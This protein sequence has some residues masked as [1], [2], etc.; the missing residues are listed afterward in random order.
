M[1]WTQVVE[2]VDVDDKWNNFEACLQTL[3]LV[4]IPMQ[5]VY[6][7]DRDKQWITPLIKLLINQRWHAYRTKNWTLY[8][9]L[10]TK[11]RVEITKAKHSW[12]KKLQ[13][14]SYGIW[15]L[16]K[17]IT[18]KSRKSD[19]SS[20]ISKFGSTEA[21]VDALAEHFQKIASRQVK[22]EDVKSAHATLFP[23]APLL[24]AEGIRKRS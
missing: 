10:K 3:L 17:H 5:E 15:N 24:T 20:L 1:D 11:V 23:K 7:T 18:N 16:A 8:D 2:A 6:M 22:D 4:C 14:C 19:F 13:N 12:A 21:L 9:H